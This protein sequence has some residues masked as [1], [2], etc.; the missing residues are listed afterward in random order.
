MLY[1]QLSVELC[2]M[3]NAYTMLNILKLNVTKLSVPCNDKLFMLAWA[4]TKIY[5]QLLYQHQ[6]L[7]I[8][9]SS[10]PTTWKTTPHPNGISITIV[11]FYLFVFARVWLVP[12]VRP[13]QLYKYKLRII[14]TFVCMKTRKKYRPA[15]RKTRRGQNKSESFAC[16]P[17]FHQSKSLYYKQ[18]P[19]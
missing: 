18:I 1:L 14:S 15:Q 13:T 16:A 5:G 2:R 10:Y 12:P 4:S 6:S 8:P 17:L 7:I 3:T 19:S 11:W 9:H